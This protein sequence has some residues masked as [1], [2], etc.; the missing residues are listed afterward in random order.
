MRIKNREDLQKAPWPFAGIRDLQGA[1]CKGADLPRTMFGDDWCKGASFRN[2]NLEGSTFQGADLRGA[3]FRGASLRDACF[4]GAKTK[5]VKLP[6]PLVKLPKRGKS[7]IC[8]K[9]VQGGIVL[10]LEV[11]KNSARVS[12]P[13]GDKCRAKKVRVLEAFESNGKRSKK[14]VF[15]SLH[16]HTFEYRIG[17][18]SKVKNYNGNPLVECTYGVHFFLDRESAENYS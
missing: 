6:K 13:I 18:V 1:N 2:A 7:F 8:W 9:K 14:K 12:T 5:G 16:D 15:S 10:K 3:D 4:E 17:E 11:L